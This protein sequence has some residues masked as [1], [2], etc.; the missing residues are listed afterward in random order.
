MADVCGL[1]TFSTGHKVQ[2]LTRHQQYRLTSLQ[3]DQWYRT[4]FALF[5]HIG[6]G[7]FAIAVMMSVACQR[8]RLLLIDAQA[9]CTRCLS[10]RLSTRWPA[11]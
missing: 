8:L 7:C 11:R 10:L 9:F 4:F 6:M 1:S 3:P 5:Q 2:I